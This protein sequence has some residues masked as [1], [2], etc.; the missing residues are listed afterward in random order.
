[1]SDIIGNYSIFYGLH[2]LLMTKRYAIAVYF[3]PNKSNASISV[4]FKA[5]INYVWSLVICI[6]DDIIRLRFNFINTQKKLI[7]VLQPPL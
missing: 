2:T 6:L 5:E 1:M 3:N 7:I 4:T